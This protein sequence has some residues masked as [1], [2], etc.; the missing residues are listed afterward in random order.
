MAADEPM[1]RLREASQLV[2]E[3]RACLDVV[4]H[5]LELGFGERVGLLQDP[6]GDGELPDVVEQ[7]AERELSLP[8]GSEAEFVGDLDGTQ[9]DSPCVL[10][11]VRILVGELDEERSDVR[12]E[13]CLLL[14][15]EVSPAQVTEE[16]S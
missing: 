9:R 16:R 6:V 13:K 12:P 8:L 11:G 1:H 5:R 14:C 10:L 15:D 7:T 4:P 2:Q 3:R